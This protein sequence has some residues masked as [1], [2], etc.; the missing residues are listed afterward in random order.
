MCEFKASQALYLGT[1]S[2]GSYKLVAELRVDTFFSPG[3]QGCYL[4][5]SSRRYS[6]A[7]TLQEQ[8]KPSIQHPEPADPAPD[9]APG[10]APE[11]A[12][13]PSF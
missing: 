7:L 9:P 2:P 8:S 12:E 11:S 6:S 4:G 5:T 1:L 10:S 3:F 13:P